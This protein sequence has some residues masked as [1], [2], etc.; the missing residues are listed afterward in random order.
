MKTYFK[1]TQYAYLLIALFL[2]YETY[3]VW[4]ENKTQTIVYGA[5]A[6]MGY[7]MFFFK[8]WYR[9]KLERENPNR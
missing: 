5:L 8:R 2:T 7:F 4:G 1:I 9:K 3:R 6:L